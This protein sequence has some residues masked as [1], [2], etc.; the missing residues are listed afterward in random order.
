MN[1]AMPV[2]GEAEVNAMRIHESVGAPNGAGSQAT[3][4]TVTTKPL[5]DPWIY[6]IVVSMLGVVMLTGMLGS[7]MLAMFASNPPAQIPDIFLALGSAAV[8]AVAGLLAPSPN[9]KR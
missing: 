6:R 7:L 5:D 9:S 3:V 4:E 2:V 8:G 1:A